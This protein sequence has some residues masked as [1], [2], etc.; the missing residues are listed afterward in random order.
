M[1]E[2]SCKCG[3]RLSAPES[4]A[5]KRARCPECKKDVEIPA[6]SQAETEGA[7]LDEFSLS[8]P[9]CNK[10][11]EGSAKVCVECGYNVLTG[12]GLIT[13]LDEPGKPRKKG[14]V[15]MVIIADIIVVIFFIIAFLIYWFFFQKTG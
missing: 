4:S 11:W 5:G 7:G 15:K 10:P 6:E 9:Q 12:E 13:E 2:F 3:H 14:L 1:V 8:C